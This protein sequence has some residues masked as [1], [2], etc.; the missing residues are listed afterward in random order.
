MTVQINTDNNVEDMVLKAYIQDE[1]ATLARLR[2][3]KYPF[4]CI[5][6][7]NSDKEGGIKRCCTIEARP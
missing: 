3:I 2:K 1:V 5:W 6:D 7:E 4:E